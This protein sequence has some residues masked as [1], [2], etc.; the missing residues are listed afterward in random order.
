M[1]ISVVVAGLPKR[2]SGQFADRFQVSLDGAQI[3]AAPA[4][5]PAG[6][7]PDYAERVY[8]RLARAL[9]KRGAPDWRTLPSLR[10]VVLYLEAP[11]D[12][13]KCLAERLSLETLLLPLRADQ[14]WGAKTANQVDQAIR[15]LLRESEQALAV[16]RDL[17]AIV[18]KQV[19]QQRNRTCL[20][21]PKANYGKRFGDIVA[22]VRDAA[23]HRRSAAQF[24]EHIRRVAESLP[25][26]SKRRFVG[27][28][29]LVFVPAKAKHGQPPLWEDGGSV[30]GGHRDSCVIR[31][32]VR[33]GVPFD[34]KTHYDCKLPKPKSNPWAR[35]FRSCHGQETTL[36]NS[37]R[38]ANIAPNDNVR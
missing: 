1:T 32:R 35:C 16:A 13:V 5:D 17:L 12:D 37:R 31:G 11:N 10:L 23:K 33:F 27:R 22:C 24:S 34:P 15:V 25:R 4:I 36:A 8:E 7:T 9:K 28:K 26:D 38:H 3:I 29:S 6:Y 14:A 30:P 20:L 18:D 21:L 19:N 2:I